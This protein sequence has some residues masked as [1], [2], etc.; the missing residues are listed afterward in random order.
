M[1]NASS[2]IIISQLRGSPDCVQHAEANFCGFPVIF[3][4]LG[5]VK[6]KNRSSRHH[7]GQRSDEARLLVVIFPRGRSRF[8]P[9]RTALRQMCHAVFGA[10][11]SYY[12]A[13]LVNLDAR[14]ATIVYLPLIFRFCAGGTLGHEH[15][16]VGLY[17]A[18]SL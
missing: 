14:P 5:P 16:L 10:R 18:S 3:T 2:S 7:E 13:I 4:P 12:R 9:R 11:A 1:Q 15:D 6:L 17:D 8:S